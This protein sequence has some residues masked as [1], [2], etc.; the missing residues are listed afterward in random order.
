MVSGKGAEAQRVSGVAVP[1]L[2]RLLLLL[3]AGC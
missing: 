1:L 2:L 3:S